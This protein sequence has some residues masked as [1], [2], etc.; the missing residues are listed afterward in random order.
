[1]TNVA[2]DVA[3]FY[4]CWKYKLVQTSMENIME[5]PQTIKNETTVW[6]SNPTSGYM[7]KENEITLSV[8]YL[9]SHVYG[10]IADYSWEMETT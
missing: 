7:S 1:M 8:T 5:V 2:K 6:S 10:S 9:H 4:C 3:H